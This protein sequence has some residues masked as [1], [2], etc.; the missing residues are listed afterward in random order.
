MD[1]QIRPPPTS[2]DATV[3]GARIRHIQEKDKLWNHGMT[4]GLPTHAATYNLAG[5]RLP[6]VSNVSTALE[7]FDNLITDGMIGDLP[8]VALSLGSLVS[9]ILNT[10]SIMKQL[11]GKMSGPNMLAFQSMSYLL[12]SVEQ[13]EGAGF[14]TGTRVNQDVYQQNAIN[15]IGQATGIS[16]MVNV[17]QR[18]QYDTSLF[19][20]D[21]LAPVV[22][23]IASPHGTTYRSFSPSGQMVNY[24]PVAVAVAAKV[25]TSFLSGAGFPGV[26]PGQNMFGGSSSVMQDMSNRLG[27]TSDSLGMLQAIARDPVGVLINEGLRAVNQGGNPLQRMFPGI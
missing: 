3:N 6:Q 16:D 12:Q 13:T 25:V 27:T 2:R 15:L 17:F 24:T 5:M 10:V 11:N 4:R 18:L 20:L 7:S 14:M 21:T 9:T 19:G 23:A 1:V 22:S 8:G 26:I